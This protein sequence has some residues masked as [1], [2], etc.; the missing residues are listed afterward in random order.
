MI[1]PPLTAAELESYVARFDFS[2]FAAGYAINEAPWDIITKIDDVRLTGDNAELAKVIAKKKVGDS[3]KLTLW[4]DGK[5]ITLSVTLGN[6]SE[7]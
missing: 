4:R 3:I 5:E 2:R 1:S 7:E 6:Q